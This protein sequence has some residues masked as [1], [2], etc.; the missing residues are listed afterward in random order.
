M[1]DGKK[2]MRIKNI[3]F[4]RLITWPVVP[5]HDSSLDSLST[6]FSKP[7]EKILG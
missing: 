1:K 4:P 3:T 6:R 5:S 2:S 7:V